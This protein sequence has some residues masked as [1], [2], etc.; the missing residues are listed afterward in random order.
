MCTGEREGVHM[1]RA[2]G[3]WLLGEAEALAG[4]HLHHQSQLLPVVMATL[5]EPRSQGQLHRDP[6]Y[7]YNIAYIYIYM[8]ALHVATSEPGLTRKGLG[9]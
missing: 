7:M 8:N 4:Y 3:R 9:E 2:E 6:L 5:L 1:Y